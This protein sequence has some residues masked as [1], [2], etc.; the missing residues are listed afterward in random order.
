MMMGFL[1]TTAW[2]ARPLD[3][4]PR[5]N[6]STVLYLPQQNPSDRDEFKQFLFKSNPTAE[7]RAR[8]EA[9]EK[10]HEDKKFH[11]LEGI[12]ES[13]RDIEVRRDLAR[14]YLKSLRQAHIK[15]TFGIGRRA[16]VKQWKEAFSDDKSQ[17]TRTRHA[18]KAKKEKTRAPAT[19]T[20]LV[21]E[22]G[23]D[24]GQNWF[25]RF[26]KFVERLTNAGISEQ[27]KTVSA[28][29]RLNPRDSVMNGNLEL[30]D[31]VHFAV[32]YRVLPPGKKIPFSGG[33]SNPTDEQVNLIGG[34]IFGETGLS[35]SV[36]YEVRHQSLNLN[37][38]KQIL[39]PLVASL[40]RNWAF[41]KG[42][43]EQ[44]RAGLSLAFLF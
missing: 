14:T 25:E 32:R 3:L 8:W 38:T 2:G 43:S 37:C 29:L 21:E 40:D 19:N 28:E 13:L 15:Q 35:S 24:D 5:H 34:S 10:I 20:V 17:S 22:Q 18:T 23:H 12:G 9:I 44:T 7:A 16:V 30:G 1:S 31:Y 41:K 6:N 4:R 11:A 42:E 39:G 33:S 26:T 27:G 36:N